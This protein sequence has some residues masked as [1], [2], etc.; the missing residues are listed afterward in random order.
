MDESGPD[1]GGLLSGNRGQSTALEYTLALAVAS[2]VVTGLL[3]TAGDFVTQQRSEVVRTELG[4]VGQ[5]LAGDVVAA[6]RLA[7]AG[8]RTETVAVNAS[9]PRTVAGAGYTVEVA[10]SGSGQWLHL[11]TADPSVGVSVRFETETV[12]ATGSVSGG[13]VSVVYDEGDPGD[14]DEPDDPHLEVRG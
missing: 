8:A 4:V 14:P 10:D 7:R 1:D 3:V 12:V 6:D 13:D 2:L 9:L 11:S 5:Q